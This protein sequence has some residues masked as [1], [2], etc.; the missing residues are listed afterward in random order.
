MTMT[1]VANLTQAPIRYMRVYIDG[2]ADYFTFYNQFTGLFWMPTGSHTIEVIATDNKGN[3]VS[4]SFS[5]NV[6]GSGA[7]TV[8]DIQNIP[9]WEPCSG[10]YAPGTPRAGQICAAGLGDAVSTMTE[11]IGSPSLSGSSAHFSMGGCR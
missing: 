3:D 7:Q 4:T 2:N 9:N 8:T 6:T 1:A 5:V 11:G 10:L